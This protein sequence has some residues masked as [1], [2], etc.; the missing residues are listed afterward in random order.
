LVS[1]GY[2]FKGKTTL[3]LLYALGWVGRKD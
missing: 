2:V 1:V 3:T